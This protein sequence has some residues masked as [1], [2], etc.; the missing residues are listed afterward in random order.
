MKSKINIIEKFQIVFYIFPIMMLFPSGFITSYVTIFTLFSFYYLYQLNHK[1]RLFL[2]D[3]LLLIFFFIS[4]FSTLINFKSDYIILL[5]SLTDFRF[6][7]LFII[8]RNLFF[9]KIVKF[10]MLFLITAICTIFLSFDIFFQHIFGY[11]LFGF[12]P[13]EGR[14]NGVFNDEAIAGSYIQKFLIISIIGV[15]FT[16]LVNKKIL[17]FL[18]TN[19]IGLGILFSLDR[20]PYIIFFFILLLS[21]ILVK[22]YRLTFILSSILSLIVFTIIFQNNEKVNYRYKTLQNEINIIKAFNIITMRSDF[23]LSK[24]SS[25]EEIKHYEE[26]VVNKSLFK[27]DYSKIAFSAYEVIKKNILLGSG[28]KSF[29]N[30]CKKLF[31]SNK[32]LLCAPHPHNMHLEI[33]VNTG[34]FGFFIFSLFIYKILVENLK[35]IFIPIS[36][37]HKNLLIF[38]LILIVSELFPLRSY[39]SIFQ[40]V[41]GS[42]FWYLISMASALS[43]VK[44]KSNN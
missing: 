11:D 24:N 22:K 15:L 9:Y 31:D 16:N 35:I 42:M 20:M 27:G 21:I 19:F 14:Y 6:A 1:I 30:E 3:Y 7:L 5:K 26:T 23:G 44:L 2:V 4:F 34:V 25:A 13:S 18:F 43:F 36:R 10:R 29:H 33:I 12:R 8:I 37:N 38:S 40:T 41:N 28:I 39:G 17:L 32:K